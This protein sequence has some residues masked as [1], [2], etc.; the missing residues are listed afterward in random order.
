MS[1]KNFL[2]SMN[3]QDLKRH[4]KQNVFLF[5][6]HSRHRCTGISPT[7][8]NNKH[9]GKNFFIEQKYCTQYFLTCWTLLLQGLKPYV[10]LRVWSL[11]ATQLGSQQYLSFRPLKAKLVEKSPQNSNRFDEQYKTCESLHLLISTILVCN[12]FK[13]ELM[14]SRNCITI[15]EI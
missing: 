3:K 7:F 9:D 5:S 4:C 11:I 8:W 1:R 6:W 15:I 14:L 2:N 12:W 13:E 10:L